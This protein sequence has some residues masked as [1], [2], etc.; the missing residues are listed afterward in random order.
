VGNGQA[1]RFWEDKWLNNTTLREQFPNF[2]NIVRNKTPLVAEVMSHVNLNLS[3]RRPII[4]IKLM[5][6]QSLV[7]LLASVNLNPVRDTF[8]WEAHR[9][10]TFST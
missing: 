1:T 8:V 4:V 10:G 9:D 5:E 3:F 7:H 2:F 6:L